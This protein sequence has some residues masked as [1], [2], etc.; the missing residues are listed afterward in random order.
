VT[1]TIAVV[2]AGPGIGLAVAE[3]F[4]REGFQV[5]LLARDR[6][7]LT[8]LAARLEARGIRAE[9]F[10]AD[11]LDQ[12]GLAAELRRVA[13]RFGT[14]DVLEY[15]PGQD[16][17]RINTPKNTAV[18]DQAYHLELSVLGAVAAVQGVLPG[19]IQRK[20]GTLLF[21]APASAAFPVVMTGGTGVAGGAALNYA[22]LLNRE[23][24]PEGIHAGMVLVAGFVVPRGQ[25]QGRHPSGFSLVTPE[26]VA[27]QHWDLHTKRD[28]VTAFVGDLAPLRAV[29]AL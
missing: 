9:A 17:A 24:A 25:E 11:V 28:R 2:G 6:G 5:A 8:V 12:E 22:R 3:R 16:P 23:L 1:E 29:A 18:A 27:E 13:D 21:T 26:D 19:M 4:G 7:R 10:P 20:R 14:I 15:G